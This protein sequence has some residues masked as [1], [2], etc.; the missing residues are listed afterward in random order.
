MAAAT[1]AGWLGVVQIV[2]ASSAIAAA[3]RAVYI[4][5]QNYQ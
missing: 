1:F 5:V 4:F 2:F 3:G